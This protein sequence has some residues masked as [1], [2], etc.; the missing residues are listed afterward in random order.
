MPF[1]TSFLSFVG[2]NSFARRDKNNRLG[3][4]IPRRST[5]VEPTKIID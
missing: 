2:A 4:F 5:K 3:K 1:L